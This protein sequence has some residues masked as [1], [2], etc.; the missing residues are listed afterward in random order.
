MGQKYQSGNLS[1]IGKKGYEHWANKEYILINKICVNRN[2]VL[3]IKKHYL[4]K[5]KYNIPLLI[6][7]NL[8]KRPKMNSFNRK[9]A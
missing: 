9:Y 1:L 8:K 2:Q 3:I 4:N 6:L 7:N 5:C